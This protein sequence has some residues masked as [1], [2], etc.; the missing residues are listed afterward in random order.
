M[1]KKADVNINVWN[2]SINDDDKLITV[3]VGRAVFS[4]K[5][6]KAPGSDY[7]TNCTNQINYTK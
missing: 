5:S 4:M 2:S 7:S 3:E 1:N 6:A